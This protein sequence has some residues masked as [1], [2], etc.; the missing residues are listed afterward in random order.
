M[1]IMDIAWQAWPAISLAAV[2][3]V[4]LAAAMSE[5]KAARHRRRRPIYLWH[6]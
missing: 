3:L 4:S 2:G 5:S 6:R 1:S